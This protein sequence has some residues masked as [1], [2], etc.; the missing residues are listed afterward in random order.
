MPEVGG[1]ASTLYDPRL[2]VHVADAFAGTMGFPIRTSA[3]PSTSIPSSPT[4]RSF[5]SASFLNLKSS[6]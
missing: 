3:C 6:P 2:L 5:K 1:F 4:D